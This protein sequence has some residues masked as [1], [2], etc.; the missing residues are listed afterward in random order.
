M[1]GLALCLTSLF[2]VSGDGL[3][4]QSLSAAELPTGFQVER[5]ARLWEHNPFTLVTPIAPPAQPSPLDNLYLASWLKEGDKEVIFVQNSE[6]N[7]VQR[8]T[9]E[10]GQN[11]V[12]LVEMHLNPNPQLVEAIISDGK[13]QAGIKFRFEVPSA[14]GQTVAGVPQMPNSDATVQ[15]PNTAELAPKALRNAPDNMPNAQTPG[16]PSTAPVKQTPRQ[17]IYP[18][19]KRVHFEGG[20]GQ[21][22][23]VPKGARLKQLLPNPAPAQSND[24]SQG[25]SNDKP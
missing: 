11:K 14:A 7:E 25:Q 21:Q 20:T 1:P 2:V 22:A 12:R 6:T 3:L 17:R 9:A 4:R 19:V 5:Y 16:L 18:G 15:T 23:T 13:K 8:F 24:P 10:P